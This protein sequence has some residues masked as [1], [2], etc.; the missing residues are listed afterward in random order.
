MAS[1]RAAAPG[2]LRALTALVR[3]AVEHQQQLSAAFQLAGAVDWIGHTRARLGRPNSAILLA[4]SSGTLCGFV[5]IRV[6]S[7]GGETAAP[8]SLAGRLLRRAQP[9]TGT[10]VKR[11]VYGLIEDIYVNPEYR[12]AQLGTRLLEAASQ[13]FAARD[14][15][16]VEAA[17]WAANDASLCFFRKL[18]FAP[19]RIL[20]R[21]TKPGTV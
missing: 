3:A 5:D 15:F 20:M 18:D 8:R 16:D 17:V 11:Q 19:A 7:R 12:G 14:I 6:V 10:I 21:R 2:D 9:Q 1:I 13:W 4:E